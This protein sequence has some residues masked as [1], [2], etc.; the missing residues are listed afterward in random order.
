MSSLTRADAALRAQTIDVTAYSVDLDLTGGDD[1]DHATFGSRSTVTFTA[2]PGA[3]SFLDLKP[4]QV[5]SIVLNGTAIDPS[6]VAGGRVDLTDLAADNTVVVEATMAYSNDGQGLHRAV[7]P[8]DGQAYVYGHLFLD[9]A[10]RVFACFD[11]PDLK[12]PFTVSVTAPEAWTV[13]GNGA[14]APAGAGRWELATTKPLATYFVTVCAGPYASVT[15]EHDGIPLGIHARASLGEHL[16]AQAPEMLQVTKDAFDYYHRLFGI[17]YP[18]GSYH[19]VFVPEFNA[20][21]MENPGCVTFRDTMIFRGAA[22]DDERLGRA[23]TICHELAHM[24][25]GDLVTMRW[26]DDLWLNESFAEYLA[27]RTLTAISGSDDAAVATT[28]FRKTWGY[29]AERA[30]STHP[31]AGSPAPDADTA[32]QNFDGISYAKG[33]AVLRQLIAHLGDGVFVTGITAYLTEHAHGNAALADFLGAMEKASG[34]SLTGWAEAWL[35]TAGLDTIRAEQA[36]DS[37]RITRTRPPGDTVSRPHTLDV[38]GWSQGR[39]VLSATVVLDGDETTA[40]ARAQNPVELLIPNAGDLTWATV[41]LSDG[42]LRALP[43]QLPQVTEAQHRAVVWVALTDGLAHGTVDPQLVVDT[44][45][46]AWPRENNPAILSRSGALLTTRVLGEYLNDRSVRAAQDAVAGAAR[47]RLESA[48]PGSSQALAAARVLAVTADT[49]LLGRWAA[50]EGLPEGLAGDADFR[51][52]VLCSL[53]VAGAVLAQDLEKVRQTDNSV[54][55]NLGALT[56]RAALP[57][58]SDKAWAWEQLVGQGRSNHERNAVAAGFW[59][60][61][62]TDLVRPYVARFHRDVPAL[63]GRVGQDALARVATIAYPSTVVEEATATATD[64]RLAAGDLSPAVRRAL[65]DQQSVLREVLA[66]RAAFGS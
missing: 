35:T 63:E 58:E 39:E 19:Q 56:A 12:A 27:Q 13:L 20:G 51:W 60:G 47:A 52:L 43:E 30:P 40:P 29:A 28:I 53:A 26:W 37:V 10:S 59:L 14:A 44:F 46:A 11:Q 34:R 49:E 61:R 16:R 8:A 36:E 41:E 5:H 32:L 6:T 33:A 45:A 42:S 21:A 3:S 55:G 31:V 1:P 57:R 24:W 50:G 2:T 54:Q 48:Q 25:F 7:D 62:H 22:T 4:V 66:S 17:R 38:A 65:T 18:F 64:E 23:N 15:D 9:A